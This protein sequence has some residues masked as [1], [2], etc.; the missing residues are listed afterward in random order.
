[1]VN[2]CANLYEE[3]STRYAKSQPEQNRKIILTFG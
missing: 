2:V 1:M 3:N